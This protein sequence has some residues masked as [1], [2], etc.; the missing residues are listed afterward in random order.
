MTHVCCFIY[1][2][3]SELF[4]DD[5]RLHNSQLIGQEGHGFKYLMTQL[6]QERLTIGVLCAAHAEWMF[7]TTREYVKQRKA[8]G[9]TISALQV[10]NMNN[11]IVMMQVAYTCIWQQT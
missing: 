8:F 2:D 3:T 5:V 6:P 11:D 7:E 1:Q 9:R 10:F 4:F